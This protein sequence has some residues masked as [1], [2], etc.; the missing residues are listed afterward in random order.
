MDFA[1]IIGLL[2][3]VGILFETVGIQDAVTLFFSREAFIVIFGGIIASSLIQYPIRDL[4][5][6]LGRFKVLFFTSGKSYRDHIVLI[7]R[8]SHKMH[9]QGRASLEKDLETIN[10]T[11][12]RHAIELVIANYPPEQIK[13]MMKEMIENSEK[14]HEQGI[15][16]F[17]Q[18]AKFAP[19]FALVGTLIG[20]VKLLANI[21][22][23]KSL[24][25]NMATA[26]VA[27]FYGVTM[28]NLVFLPLAGRLRVTSYKERIHKEI[29]IEGIVSM[30]Q[31]E[32][33]YVVKEKIMML[34]TDKDRDYIKA[35]AKA[36]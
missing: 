7:L 18:M 24:G 31:G 34:V 29:L 1:I 14:R 6:V 12:I 15:F 17:D 4:I 32:L 11:F 33:P 10:D 9:T 20:L 26:L 22:D 13:T 28:S 8:L 35:Q 23:P 30:A 3:V 2:L 5:S 16:Y 36:S 19:G 21:S 27:T 25:P